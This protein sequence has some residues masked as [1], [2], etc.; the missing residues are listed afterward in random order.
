MLF[1]V[2]SMAHSGNLIGLLFVVALLLTL[3]H[4]FSLIFLPRHLGC[5]WPRK[6][7]CAA[8]GLSAVIWFYLAV[9]AAPLDV[10]PLAVLYGGHVIQSV[11]LALLFAMSL[12]AQQLRNLYDSLVAR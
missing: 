9:L 10:G 12:N 7:A 11:F 4:A 2:S 5:R 6:L 1:R 8:A 3:P